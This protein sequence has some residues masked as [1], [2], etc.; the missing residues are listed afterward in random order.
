LLAAGIHSEKT[1]LYYYY[2]GHHFSRGIWGSQIKPTGLRFFGKK[3][4]FLNP[5]KYADY[6]SA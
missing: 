4:G 2:Y 6:A 1:A 3:T 5:D